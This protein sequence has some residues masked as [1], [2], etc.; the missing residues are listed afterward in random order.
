MYIYIYIYYIYIY[1]YIYIYKYR[2]CESCER[3]CL[4][5]R[6]ILFL[7]TMFHV[8]SLRIQQNK[9]YSRVRLFLG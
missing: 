2:H 5:V 6:A 7:L 9:E 4:T 8:R 3:F 1:I